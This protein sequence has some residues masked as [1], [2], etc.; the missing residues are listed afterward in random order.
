MPDLRESIQSGLAAFEFSPLR[1]SALRFLS[2]LGYSSDRTLKLDRSSP[3]AFLDFI[4]SQVSDSQFNE[5]KAL[6]EAWKTA[7][8]LFQLTDDELASSQ[9]LFRETDI[10]PGLLKSY[11]FFA[12]ELTGE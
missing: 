6:F 7:D 1:E 9:S 10:K 3:Q 2:T 4:R 8:L 12:I 11:V 5:P